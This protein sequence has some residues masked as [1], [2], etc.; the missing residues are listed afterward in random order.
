MFSASAK[1][2]KTMKSLPNWILWKLETIKGRLSK[3]PYS[4]LY[5]GRASST[6]PE[7]W[8]T[9]ENVI[10]EYEAHPDDYS[11]IGFVFSRDAGIVFID[12][13]GCIFGGIIDDRAKD[14][15]SEIGKDAFVELSQSG[16]GLHLFI[17][18]TIPAC[19]NNREK[20]VEMY[21]NARFCAMTGNCFKDY[22]NELS[23][24]DEALN[25]VYEAYKTHYSDTTTPSMNE[26][27]SIS[28]TDEEIIRRAGEN[29]ISG[30]AF[31]RLYSGDASGYPSRSEADLRLCQILAFWC[32]RDFEQI[33]RIVRSS[34][35]YRDKWERKDYQNSTIMRACNSLKEDFSGYIARMQ[36][37]DVKGF[38][39][40]FKHTGDQ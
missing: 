32:D 30:E 11:G 24:N 27:E 10:K 31:K 14:I 5:H 18:G 26:N 3:I 16:T 33:L 23:S 28:Y 19:F 1:Y 9:F 15:L 6:N 2:P 29:E 36:R 37:E 22:D 39:D 13:D 21:D 40:I 7:T 38:G 35:A 4:A 20:H 17:R 34:G 25:R 8:T 12:I